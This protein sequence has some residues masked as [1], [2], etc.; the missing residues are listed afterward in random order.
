MLLVMLDHKWI[1]N[2]KDFCVE[3]VMGEIINISFQD[4][5]EVEEILL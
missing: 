4:Q 5:G 3:F 2:M 1:V